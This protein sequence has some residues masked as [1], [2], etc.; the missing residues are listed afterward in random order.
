MKI[1]YVLLVALSLSLPSYGQKKQSA[2]AAPQIQR[3]QQIQ[4][5][6]KPNTS[7]QNDRDRI[8]IPLS[9]ELIDY[10]MKKHDLNILLQGYSE[11]WLRTVGRDP[12]AKTNAYQTLM[13]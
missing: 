3:V 11:L 5:I 9:R 13:S 7:R 1:R 2:K 4:R 12:E 8:N 6:L 10:G